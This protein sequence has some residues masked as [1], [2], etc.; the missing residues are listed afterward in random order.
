MSNDFWVYAA[1]SEHIYRRDS[2]KD[3][4]FLEP[5]LASIA[6]AN[7]F[8]LDEDR[9]NA[10][11]GLGLGLEIHEDRYIYNPA[12][13]FEAM[14]AQVDGNWTLVFRGTDTILD[15][16]QT[17]ADI[18]VTAGWQTALGMAPAAVVAGA[19]AQWN[20]EQINEGD[21]VANFGLGFGVGNSQWDDARALTQLVID[22]SLFA[23]GNASNVVVTGQSLGGGLAGLA[24]AYFDIDGKLISPAPFQHQLDQEWAQIAHLSIREDAIAKVDSNDSIQSVQEVYGDA[25][26]TAVWTA[27]STASKVQILEAGFD[28]GQGSG[29]PYLNDTSLEDD[30][31]A[32]Y[33]AAKAILLNEFKASRLDNL[34]M[35][36]I[37]LTKH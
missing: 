20:S 25:P 24:A 10:I 3:Q 7:V 28:D 29:N 32:T 30:I 14:I 27:L 34:E 13:G 22:S 31:L 17:F 15:A 33:E 19:V 6:S 35:A 4:A 21:W 16:G 1:L 12:N 26:F 9:I 5:E 2:T 8:V 37:Y 36:I 11:E 23:G 18:G